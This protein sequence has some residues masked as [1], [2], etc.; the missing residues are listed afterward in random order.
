MMP[1]SART[2]VPAAAVQN[3]SVAKGA[4]LHVAA[5]VRDQRASVELRS[6]RVP[7]CLVDAKDRTLL[8][9]SQPCNVFACSATITV[10]SDAGE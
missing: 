3:N 6:G 7:C 2:G 5:R 10:S 9:H 1:T 4:K 8:S